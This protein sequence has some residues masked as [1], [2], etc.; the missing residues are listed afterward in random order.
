MIFPVYFVALKNELSTS[1]VVVVCVVYVDSNI[2]IIQ[3]TE[4]VTSDEQVGARYKGNRCK[5]ILI[6]VNI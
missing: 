5:Y 6:Y 4:G 1:S 2:Y 3:Y